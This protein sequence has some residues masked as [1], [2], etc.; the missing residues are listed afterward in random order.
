V[1]ENVHHLQPS[2]EVKFVIG[3]REDYDWSKSL[4]ERYRLADRCRLLVSP[5]F[6]VLE[7]V[8][9]ADWVLA[10]RLPAR[11]QLQLHKFV[12]GPEVRGV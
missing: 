1:Y 4:I 11:V 7:P 6:G 2:D 12:W 3:N 5:V 9:L 10:D 8:E